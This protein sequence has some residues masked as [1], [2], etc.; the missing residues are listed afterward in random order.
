MDPKNDT[1]A[2]YGFKAKNELERVLAKNEGV[3]VNQVAGVLLKNEVFFE[4]RLFPCFIRAYAM[5]TSMAVAYAGSTY[6]ASYDYVPNSYD[7]W[8]VKEDE[9][10][11]VGLDVDGITVGI[12]CD[13]AE[14]AFFVHIPLNE[15]NSHDS[16]MLAVAGTISE[17][18]DKLKESYQQENKETVKES[19]QKAGWSGPTIH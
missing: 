13:V 4:Q 14:G 7:P 18:Q 12:F 17:I 2:Q 9:L 15:G 8:V 16:A 3:L 6:H 5:M 10:T 11:A 1:D 19:L